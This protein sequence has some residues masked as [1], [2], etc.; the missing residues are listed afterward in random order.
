MEIKTKQC[1]KCG[2][3]KPVSEF[4]AQ[5]ANN[6]GLQTYC[7]ICDRKKHVEYHRT[8]G[9]LIAQIYGSQ[10]Y[11]SKRRGHAL[12]TY[13]KQELTE[14]LYS[15]KL[16]HELFDNWKASGYDTM[17]VPSVDRK[18]DSIGYSL[19]NIQLMTWRE[20]NNKGYSDRKNG[21]NNKASKAVIQFSKE[22]EFIAEYYSGKEAFRQTGIR[23]GSISSCCLGISKTSGGYIWKFKEGI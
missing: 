1:S 20:N 8:K 12:P 7:K 10:K 15:Q 23:Q 2:E 18:D 13:T 6:D 3:I 11:R 14:W 5:P 17:L 4:N 21:I 16:F 19:G 9:G 22:G